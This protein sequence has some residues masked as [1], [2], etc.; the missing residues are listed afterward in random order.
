MQKSI[1]NSTECVCKH[2]VTSIN[3]LSL[4]QYVATFKHLQI[5]T[6]D[7]LN[8]LVNAS[9]VNQAVKGGV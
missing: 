1:R 4:F 8:R 3:T 9:C 6:V 5:A 7:G 2:H